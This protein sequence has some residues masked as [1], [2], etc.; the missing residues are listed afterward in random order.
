M[1]RILGMSPGLR[2]TAG[3]RVRLGQPAD[4]RPAGARL[5]TR[6][7]A[8]A[9]Q[10]ACHVPPAVPTWRNSL[11]DTTSTLTGGNERTRP[12]CPT[13]SGWKCSRPCNAGTTT[14]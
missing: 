14:T 11:P 5:R 2:L 7:R 10:V 13:G 8:R 6:R 9:R 12:A 1:L 4:V 3:L